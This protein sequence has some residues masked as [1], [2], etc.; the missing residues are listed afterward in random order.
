MK[1]PKYYED[2]KNLHIGTMPNRAYYVP[3]YPHASKGSRI[4]S[5]NG[6]WRFRFYP[7]RYEVEE[8]FFLPS[9]DSDSYD[10]IPVPGCWQNHGY[11]R[12]QYTNV[13]YPFPYDFPYVPEENNPCGCYIHRF[14]VTTEQLSQQNYLYFE[15]VD[16]C[17]YVWLNG[18]FIGFSQV[19]HSSSEF[20]VTAHLKAGENVLAVLVMKWCVGSYY[21]DQ[22]KF[23]MSGIFRNVSL[24]TRAREHIRDYFVKTILNEDC[25]QANIKISLEYLSNSIPVN[26]QLFLGDQLLK[27]EAAKGNSVEFIVAQPLLWNAEAP[28][29]Y[30]LKFYTEE[31]LIVQRV[32]IR[33]VEV[34]DSVLFFNNVPIKLKGVNR[35]DSDP[36]TGYT[37]SREQALRDL[38][39]MKQHNINAI[40]TSHYPNAPWFTELCDEYGFYVIGEAD[41]ETHGV[42]NFYSGSYEHTYCDIAKNEL[43]DSIILDREQRNVHRD[44]NHPSILMWSMGNES[45]WGPSFEKAGRWIKEF[46][47]TRLLH[48]EGSVHAK[49]TDRDLSMLDVHSKMYDSLADIE[50]YF[51]QPENKKPYML[52]EFCHAMGNGPG[53]LEDYMEML[54]QEQSFIG[55][56]VW[57]WCDHAIYLGETEDGRKRY[58]YGGDS[59]EFPHDGNFC[60]DGLVYPDRTVSPSL[61]EYK[62]VLRPVRASLVSAE[63]GLISLENKLDFTNTKHYL[64]LTYEL[65]NDGITFAEGTLQEL[66]IPPQSRREIKLHYS[67]PDK[68]TT[69]LLLRYSQKQ[70]LPLTESGHELGFDQLLIK[71]D[72]RETGNGCETSIEAGEISILQQEEELLYQESESRIIISGKQFTYTFNKLTGLFEAMTVN[73]R[74]LLM[75]PMEYNIWRAP[76][77]NDQYIRKDWER[78]G[79]DRTTVRVYESTTQYTPSEGIKIHVRLALA[80]IQRE[81]ILELTVLWNISPT[82]A[83]SVDIQAHRN[84]LMPYLPRFGLR[85]FL[86]KEYEYV[87]YYGYGPSESYIDKHRA[88]YVGLFEQTIDELF[89]DYIYPQENGSHYGCRHFSAYGTDTLPTL[90]VTANKDFSF[91]A[92]AYSQEE[93]TAKKHN[94]ELEKAPYHSFC[95]DY[96]MSGIGSNSCGPELLSKYRLEE[97][98]FFCSFQM[99]WN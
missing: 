9:F 32:G 75:K 46:D 33:K 8:D 44:K 62:N 1:L 97:E 66:D 93:L 45:G 99:D 4:S 20:D 18:T 80:A 35:H 79:Y 12:H 19:S 26:I 5:L 65:Q 30:T 48:Y 86:P 72:M 84:I 17:F 58:A 60:I 68:G 21:E 55:A 41:V 64:S 76:T 14:E 47:D 82:G 70:V 40:R 13:N 71:E 50:R 3:Q 2:T 6:L 78:A 7:N 92:S 81:H 27:E 59:G 39:L 34:K 22:D 38:S 94:Y 25:T 52:C 85:L 56:F 43:S 98:D 90:T 23:R 63:Q 11:D 15:G 16:S 37:I 69:Y 67:I 57:E 31:E 83:I 10:Q 54:Y 87:K 42:V 89:E 74:I 95:I 24:I 88:S 96:K 91:Q 28:N 73:N 77:D 51:N 61:R 29:L 53:D 36:V 49:D